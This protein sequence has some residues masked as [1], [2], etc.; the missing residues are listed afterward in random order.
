M[1]DLIYSS[2]WFHEVGIV[3]VPILQMSSLSLGRNEEFYLRLLNQ[4]VAEKHRLF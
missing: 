3:I 4:E 2:Q 1:P